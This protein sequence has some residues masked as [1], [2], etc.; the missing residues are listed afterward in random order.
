MP[1]QARQDGEAYAT[2]NYYRRR[3]GGDLLIGPEWRWSV[4]G[5]LE[6][7]AG[8]GL[9]GTFIY[10]PGKS[11]YR[12]FSAVPLGVGAGAVL[13]WPTRAERLSRVVTVGTY[14][15]VAY[16]LYDPMHADDLTHGFTLRLGVIV[17]LGERR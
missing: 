10:L 6:A 2:A 12:D 1:L 8:P 15:S 11:G 13:R 5:D 17:G 4:R 7:E 3:S 16:D 9:H 14:A